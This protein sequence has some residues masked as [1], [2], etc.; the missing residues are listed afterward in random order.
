MPKLIWGAAEIGKLIGRDAKIHLSTGR[1]TS[2]KPTQG[3]QTDCRRPR[4]LAARDCRRRSRAGVAVMSRALAVIPISIQRMICDGC[5]AETNAA[6]NCGVA[7]Q[8]K[9]VRA[10]EAVE[11]HPREVRPG[12][13]QGDWRQS[14]HGRQGARG[15]VQ[16][17]TVGR[18][19]AHRPRWQDPE[20]AGE[21]VAGA[22]CRTRTRM[23]WRWKLRRRGASD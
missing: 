5:G 8:P 1:R 2:E 7:Y 6:C 13:R 21:E 16:R 18:G 3:R 22:S 10:R 14:D 11:A 19:A 15:T 9:A 20:N 4:C 17:W 23:W 12:N